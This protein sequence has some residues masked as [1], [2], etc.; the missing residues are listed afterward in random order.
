MKF[1]YGTPFILESQSALGYN[2]TISLTLR[3]CDPLEVS[4]FGEKKI[5]FK[6]YL[7]CTRSYLQPAGSSSPTRAQTLN[8]LHWDLGVLVTGPQ[9]KSLDISA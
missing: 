9:G 6:I 5:F 4:F 1:I 8:P 3:Q 7:G 2:V